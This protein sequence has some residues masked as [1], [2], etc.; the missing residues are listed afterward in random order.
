MSYLELESE[1]ISPGS[2][3]PVSD[4]RLNRS[5]DNRSRERRLPLTM[6]I[7][8]II[9]FIASYALAIDGWR[10]L[11]DDE[12]VLMCAI[13]ETLDCA[14]AMELWQ[15]S[16][17]G[18]P[19]PYVG[20]M[21]FT[22]VITL[23]VVWL[24]MGS[25]PRWLRIGL[26]IGTAL[27]QL[28]VFFLMYTTFTLLDA[29][30]PWC[31]VVWIIMWPLLWLQIVDLIREPMAAAP[32]VSTSSTLGSTEATDEI[33]GSGLAQLIV[34]H[35]WLFLALGYLLALITGLATM[36]ARVLR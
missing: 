32:V 36:G 6:L 31:T 30:C 11:V 26:L 10:A 18:F 5:Q 14:P 27:G 22:V 35:R 2:D 34:P 12:H 4:A 23:A 16:F 21:A 19:N 9:G 33:T 28:F 24:A 15:A 1:S 8:G 29:L 7:L 13:D 20:I 17:F 25:P 3:Q